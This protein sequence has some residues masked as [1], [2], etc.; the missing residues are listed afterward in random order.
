MAQ[1][2]SAAI[3]IKQDTIKTKQT[4]AF[5]LNGNMLAFGPQTDSS[6]TKTKPKPAPKPDTS[7][8]GSLKATGIIFYAM[9][10]QTDSLK[11]KPKAVDTVKTGTKYA[12][13][14]VLETNAFIAYHSEDGPQTDS[15][16]TK[17]ATIKPDTT[18]KPIDKRTGAILINKSLFKV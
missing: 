3:K 2:D 17:P 10:P 9:S 5:I 1:K 4:G 16:K 12:A 7:K 14:F 6:K 8:T 18:S 13:G 15:T 11:A